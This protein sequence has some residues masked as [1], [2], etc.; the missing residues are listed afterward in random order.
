MFKLNFQ[1]SLNVGNLVNFSCINRTDVYSEYNSWFHGVRFRQFSLY[2]HIGFLW[3]SCCSIFNFLSNV[4]Q[5]AIYPVVLFL[6]AI[7][8]SVVLQVTASDHPCGFYNLFPVLLVEETL[9]SQE[10]NRPGHVTIWLPNFTTQGL[11][12]DV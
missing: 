1:Q 9:L 12:Y 5:I 4:L 3:G 2:I 8:L 6:Q 10:I 7:V 11:G